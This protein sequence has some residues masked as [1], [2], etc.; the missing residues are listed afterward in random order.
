LGQIKDGVIQETGNYTDLMA[1][2]SSFSQLITEFS[3]A[4]QHGEEPTSSKSS[5]TAQVQ[6]EGLKQPIE[7]DPTVEVEN[8]TKKDDQA[9]LVAEEEAAEGNLGL[10]VIHHY[11]QAR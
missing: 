11:A 10:K 7:I 6:V 1:A 2:G 3:V 5:S 9:E 4:D 8:T